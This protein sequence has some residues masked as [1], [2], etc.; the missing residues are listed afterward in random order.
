MM[1]SVRMASSR[2]NYTGGMRAY[3]DEPGQKMIFCPVATNSPDGVIDCASLYAMNEDLAVGIKRTF[4][5]PNGVQSGH[6]SCAYNQASLQ[7]L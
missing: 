4:D 2:G 6:I 1:S 7:Q 3:Y 5:V